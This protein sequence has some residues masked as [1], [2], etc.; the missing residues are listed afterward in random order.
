LA[1]FFFDK[2]NTTIYKVSIKGAGRNI[3]Y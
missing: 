2:E 1:H 3:L